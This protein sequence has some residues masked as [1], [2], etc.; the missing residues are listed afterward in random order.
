ML[1][2]CSVIDFQEGPT[3]GKITASFRFV[4]ECDADVLPPERKTQ[5]EA[6]NWITW[7]FDPANSRVWVVPLLIYCWQSGAPITCDIDELTGDVV[8]I[9]LTFVPINN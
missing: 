1:K 9:N 7:T 4:Y 2:Q 5:Y 3:P 6:V 8:G